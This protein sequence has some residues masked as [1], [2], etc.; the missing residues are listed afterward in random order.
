[1][2]VG[3]DFKWIVT[4]YIF[5]VKVH[6]NPELEI[7]TIWVYPIVLPPP[8][9]AFLSITARGKV[10]YFGTVWSRYSNPWRGPQGSRRLR[11]P[12]FMTIGI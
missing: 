3:S 6:R 7:L 2:G 10:I 5:S 12:D 8:F 11:L 9:D 4:W 1:M